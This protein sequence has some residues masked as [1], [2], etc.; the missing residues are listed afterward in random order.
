MRRCSCIPTTRQHVDTLHHGQ[1]PHSW[2]NVRETD[3]TF[4]LGEH[5]CKDILPSRTIVAG[6]YYGPNRLI[7]HVNNELASM[8]TNTVKAKLSYITITQKVTLHVTPNTEFNIPLSNSLGLLQYLVPSVIVSPTSVTDNEYIYQRR[9]VHKVGLSPS[10]TVKSSDV[11][12]YHKEADSVM[13]MNQGFDTLYVHK[14]VVG[15]YTSPTTPCPNRTKT[16]RQTTCPGSREGPAGWT[17]ADS[18]WATASAETATYETHDREPTG[19]YSTE[20]S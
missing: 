19:Q 20:T 7:Q 3:A 5:D 2:Y 14:D 16:I 9:G 1:Y 15:S 11:Y 18:R 17:V 8:S 6:F 10:T 4:F 13:D 12:T